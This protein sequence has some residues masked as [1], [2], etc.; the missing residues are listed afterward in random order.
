MYY[1]RRNECGTHGQVDMAHLREA[2]RFWDTGKQHLPLSN[3]MALLLH[4]SWDLTG[5]N[6]TLSKAA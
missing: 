5:G 6:L 4:A 3:L 2:A 1:R